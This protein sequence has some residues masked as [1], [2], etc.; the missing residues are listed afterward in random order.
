MFLKIKLYGEKLTACEALM[1]SLMA[2]LESGF[3]GQD[4]TTKPA[5]V[6]LDSTASRVVSLNC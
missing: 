1:I 2:A 4:M 3:S 6:K 5:N